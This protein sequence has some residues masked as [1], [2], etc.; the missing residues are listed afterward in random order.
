MYKEKPSENFE[1]PR[2]VA[3]IKYAMEHMG[4]FKLKTAANY[5]VPEH[6]RMNTARKLVQLM[7]LQENVNSLFLYQYPESLRLK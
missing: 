1:D 5:V 2:D 6:L 3:E 7:I 4:D